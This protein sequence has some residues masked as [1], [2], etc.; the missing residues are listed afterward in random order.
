MGICQQCIHFRRIKPASQLFVQVIGTTDAAI[1]TALNKIGEDESQQKGSEAQVKTKRENANDEA[2]GFRPVMSE[3]CGLR[4]KEEIYLIC[5]V[6]NFG[7]RCT[8]FKAGSPPTN[9]CKTCVHRITPQGVAR[10]QKMEEAYGSMAR[11]SSATGSST[12]TSDNLLNKHREGVASRKAFEIS[13][14]YNAKGR[15]LTRPNYLDYCGKLSAD[16]EYVICL[17]HNPHH[18]CS[19]WEPTSASSAVRVPS[20]APSIATVAATPVV[21]PQSEKSDLLSEKNAEDVE[22]FDN[23]EDRKA[24]M[25]F[26]SF[27][28]AIFNVKLAE[29]KRNFLRQMFYESLNDEQTVGAILFPVALV[30]QLGAKWGNESLIDYWRQLIIYDLEEVSAKAEGAHLRPM[31]NAVQQIREKLGLELPRRRIDMR[32]DDYTA[33]QAVLL[34]RGLAELLY[35]KKIY[36]NLSSEFYEMLSV[37]EISLLFGVMFIEMAYVQ[38]VCPQLPES[39]NPIFVQANEQ[40]FNTYIELGRVSGFWGSEEEMKKKRDDRLRTRPG[41][42]EP[43]L[44]VQQPHAQPTGTPNSDYSGDGDFQTILEE[45]RKEIAELEAMAASDPESS[46]E[47][48]LLIQQK[49]M[50]NK[51]NNLKLISD[52]FK[53]KMEALSHIS[54]NIR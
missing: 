2:W 52:M 50:Q 1:S 24:F 30:R 12:S 54:R 26:V 48:R 17:M 22:D 42:R 13:G 20:S 19:A 31:F 47:I 16:E 35:R 37:K 3:F 43:E 45:D 44:P 51:A 39:I 41:L 29:D 23:E 15:L 4:E 8:D 10:D 40:G 21:T 27:V 46:K 49:K 5:G 11:Q 32:V 38:F 25:D 14:A 18:S 34:F 53:S 28:E 7:G 33:E 9:S 36:S 6:K